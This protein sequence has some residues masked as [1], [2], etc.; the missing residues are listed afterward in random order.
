VSRSGSG[1]PSLWE[2]SNTDAGLNSTSPSDH[3]SG[4]V[5]SYSQSLSSW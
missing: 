4:G 5:S 1:S 2:T 3:S